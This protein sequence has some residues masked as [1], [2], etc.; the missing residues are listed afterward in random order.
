MLQLKKNNFYKYPFCYIELR[1]FYFY[2]FK[3]TL[4]FS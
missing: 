2:N 4:F 1:I 3:K